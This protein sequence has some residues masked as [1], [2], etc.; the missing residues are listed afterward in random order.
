MAIHDKIADTAG[1]FAILG[2][3]TRC[4]VLLLLSKNAT[5]LYVYEIAEE[6]KMTHSAISHQ[7]AKLETSAVVDGVRDGQMVR[8]TLSTNARAKELMRV[9]KSVYR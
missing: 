9:F 4:K 6:L 7:L 5:G 8:Y 3:P 2:D 1:A